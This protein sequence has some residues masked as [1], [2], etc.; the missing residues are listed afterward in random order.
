MARRMA[1][2]AACAVA[3]VALAA[4]GGTASSGS[5]SG[6]LTIADLAPF[7]GPDAALGPTYLASCF[8]ATR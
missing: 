5:G 3:V 2:V 4:C 6:P 7:T 1:A 8:G